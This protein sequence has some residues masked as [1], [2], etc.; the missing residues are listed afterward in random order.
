[1]YLLTPPIPL[2]WKLVS[3]MPI[4]ESYPWDIKDFF[5]LLKK[6]KAANVDAL[7][8]PCYGPDGVLMTEQT[9]ALDYNPKLL[10][11]GSASWSSPLYIQK[12]GKATIEGIMSETG[13]N[14]KVPYPGARKFYDRYLLV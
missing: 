14:P 3:L 1:M 6:I 9:M 5:P 12:F 11:L 4:M 13:W 7:V 8:S 2:P 10:W